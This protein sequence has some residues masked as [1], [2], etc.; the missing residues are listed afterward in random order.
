MATAVKMQSYLLIVF[1]VSLMNGVTAEAGWPWSSATCSEDNSK[2]AKWAERASRPV[3]SRQKY[4]FGELWPPYPRPTGPKQHY[5][6]RYHHAHYW[7]YP[8]TCQDRA[9]VADIMDRQIHNGWTEQNT[10]YAYHFDKDGNKLTEAGLLHLRW[11]MEHAPEER[12]MIFVQ[13]T[14]NS[15]SSQE[16]L[17]NVQ[18][19]ASEMSDGR[20]VPSAM[21]RVSPTYGRPAREED[22]KYRAYVGSIL[23]PRIQYT[24]GGGS[25]ANGSN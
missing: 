21:L 1:A 23:A 17:A 12:R 16:R 25:A 15:I 13:T 24:T 4:K 10:L 7:P 6:N 14:N 3:G 5:W 8:Y 22:M 2:E 9:Y 20:N 19:A 11:I 18:Y